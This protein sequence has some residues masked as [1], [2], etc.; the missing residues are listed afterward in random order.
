MKLL[1]E[2]ILL[3][4]IIAL[5][6]WTWVPLLHTGFFPIHDNTQVARVYEMGK[7]LSD[8]MFPVRWVSDL[9]YGY[10]YPIFTFYAPLAYYLGGLFT[11]F[12]SSLIA[13]KVMIGIGIVFSAVTMFF[14]GRKLFG[15]WGGLLSSA[16]YLYAPYHAVDIY[17]R[18][19][20]GEL[21]AYAFIPLA[22]L[23]VV[24]LLE[25]QYWKGVI[26][27]S[28]GLSGIIVSHNLT[29]MM[30]TPFLLVSLLIVLLVKKNVWKYA[31]LLF[32]LGLGLSA[33]YIIPVF[34]EMRYTNVLSQIGG[35][36]D[37]HDH[38]VCLSQLWQSQWGYGGSA[39]GCVDGFSFM[40]GKIQIIFAI[41]AAFSV[42]FVW[43]KSKMVA[44]VIMFSLL[45]LLLVIFLML[46]QSVFI[47][48]I[49][50]PMAFIQY[51]W[52]FLLLASFFTALLG[53]GFFYIC[54]LFVKKQVQ[55]L[56]LVVVLAGTIFISA[57]YFVPEM[58]QNF[59]SS[60][61][62]NPQALTFTT[63]KISDEYMPKNFKKP[64]QPEE[65]PTTLI[66]LKEGTFH[67]ISDKTQEKK[68]VVRVPQKETAKV[69]IAYFPAWKAYVDG[70]ATA[71]FPAQDGMMISVPQ[72]S[73]VI[74][75]V[76]LET[77]VEWLGDIVSLTSIAFIILVIIKGLYGSKS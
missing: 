8:G 38:F 61:Y 25:K 7:S 35:G 65:V 33:F 57:K 41:L 9:G 15:L 56:V 20:I 36:A 45:S 13:T 69:N 4:L 63:S 55:M 51:P 18:G 42:P 75:I 10:G 39:K 28:L 74:R 1:K 66:G 24:F 40:I 11:F 49:F 5:S 70:K 50:S 44:W 52:R 30:I 17:V 3:L 68:I 29:A 46:P 23:G 60:I 37:F 59:A 43:K 12:L 31:A 54:T 2:C 21:F 34:G 16:F 6:F 64:I 26:I 77:P 73:H 27:G 22:F 67:V 53:G 58:Y 71:L 62:T 48:N 14:L 47:W 32:F 72:G 76:Y 19:D